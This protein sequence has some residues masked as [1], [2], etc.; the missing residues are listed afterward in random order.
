[1]DP[2]VKLVAKAVS[3]GVLIFNEHD[4]MLLAHITGQKFWDIPKGA[5]EPDERPAA[6][7]LREVFEETGLRLN[8]QH[9]QVLGLHHYLPRKDLYL[10]KTTVS[11]VE[12]DLV[13]CRCTSFFRHRRTG[14]LHPEVD[15]FRW[16]DVHAIESVC[17]PGMA[18]LLTSLL[19]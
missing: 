1:M 4:Q 11:S 19:V 8:P 10:F 2:R 16:V 15:D 6:A 17:T 12:Y 14:T 7:A 3:Y 9:L 13:A 5:A 18:A